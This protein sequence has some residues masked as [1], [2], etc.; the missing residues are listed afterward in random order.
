[1]PH[2][3]AFI[4]PRIAIVGSGFAGIGMAIRLKRMGITSFSIYEAAADIGGTWR[5]N[6]YPGLCCDVPSHMYSF[7]FRTWPW[8]RRFPPREEILAYLHALV[9]EHGLGSRLRLGHG[10]TA[11]EF[12]EGRALWT[13][14]LDDGSTLEAAAVV[15]A[16]GQLGRDLLGGVLSRPDDDQAAAAEQGR[17]GEGRQVARP[18]VGGTDVM[19]VRRRRLARLGHDREHGAPRPKPLGHEFCDR[20]HRARILHE[21][22]E[23]RAQ[24]KD[25]EELHHELGR[26][27]HEGLRPMGEQRLAG[28]RRR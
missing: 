16:V 3:S 20:R 6:S 10:V 11:A 15:C 18:K 13:V 19:P 28:Q 4:P 17:R 1:M 26:A 8:S 7:S 23:Q 21:L 2:A 14:T 25:R 24:K 12:D 5:D 22:A 27:R 9:A